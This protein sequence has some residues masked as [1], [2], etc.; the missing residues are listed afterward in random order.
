M[1]DMKVKA[2]VITSA[3]LFVGPEETITDDNAHHYSHDMVERFNTGSPSFLKIENCY[4]EPTVASGVTRETIE[5][6]FNELVDNHFRLPGNV[7]EFID[8]LVEGKTGY[9]KLRKGN[10]LHCFTF[11]TF[12]ISKFYPNVEK[13]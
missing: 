7:E 4:T 13:L 10:F 6:F 1:L 12:E 8:E 3:G 9:A 11:A 2:V 5:G